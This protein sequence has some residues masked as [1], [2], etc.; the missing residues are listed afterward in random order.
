MEMRPC[1]FSMSS[2]AGIRL[3]AVP[4]SSVARK[5]G[6]DHRGRGGDVALPSGDD[7]PHGGAE[8]RGASGQDSGVDAVDHRSTGRDARVKVDVRRGVG[9]FDPRRHR[10]STTAW[11]ATRRESPPLMNPNP[12]DRR[13]P[14]TRHGI[15]G[16]W[17]AALI[18]TLRPDDEHREVRDWLWRA[19]PAA[20]PVASIL[21]FCRRGVT[22]VVARE[23]KP[24]GGSR[25]DAPES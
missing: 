5:V 12:D 10:P 6:V 17:R 21:R 24:R 1:S 23:W 11:P 9:E 22:A 8:L 2:E 15:G 7:L 4:M 19:T 3:A 20:E 25:S 18:D 13:R 16:P 14:L